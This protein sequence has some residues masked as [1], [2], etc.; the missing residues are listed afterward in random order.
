M[1][2]AA[3]ALTF[4]FGSPPHRSFPSHLLNQD[5]LTAITGVPIQIIRT[6]SEWL[7]FIPLWLW[8]RQFT[9]E[10]M[11][12]FNLRVRRRLTWGMALTTLILLVLGWMLTQ[13]LG[14]QAKQ[15][16]WT[17]NQHYLRQ[18]QYCLYNEMEEIHSIARA[19][20]GSTGIAGGL[21]PGDF[22]GLQN[23]NA[24]LDRFSA[25]FEGTVIYLMNLQGMTVASSNR[26]RPDS[27]VGKSYI[28][29]P[30]FKQ[31]MTGKNGSYL[32]LG[33]T[34]KERGFYASAPVYGTD[35]KVIGVAVVK[36]SID[37][38]ESMLYQE[39]PAL[40]VNPNGIIFL[41]SRPEMTLKSLWPVAEQ[42]LPEI[43]ASRQFGGGPFPALLSQQPT[44]GGQVRLHDQNWFYLTEPSPVRG[45]AG[46]GPGIHPGDC[47][48]ASHWH[49]PDPVFLPDL[50]GSFSGLGHNPGG[51]SPYRSFGTNPPQSG[52]GGA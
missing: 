51:L 11:D 22:P 27:F 21:Q 41:A 39:A 14:N 19:V 25:A 13:L 32:A 7:L 38:I 16:T 8:G 36:R 4:G 52:G 35:Q 2:L 29:R 46:G 15:E 12:R 20:A 17:I 5:T 33:M 47:D 1:A 37:Q 18:F 43:I 45:L 26:H 40:L 49:R 30:Y 28:F 50:I 44:S 24:V 48:R 34:S 31:A 23:A 3:Y 9:P 42:T 10:E 6:I